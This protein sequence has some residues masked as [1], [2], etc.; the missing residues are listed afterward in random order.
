MTG[1]TELQ[2]P[3]HLHVIDS[4]MTSRKET[5]NT[6]QH[7]SVQS[8]THVFPSSNSGNNLENLL[9]SYCNRGVGDEKE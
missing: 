3:E 4:L 6:L 8:T 7:L 9:F 5:N 1:Q 2:H